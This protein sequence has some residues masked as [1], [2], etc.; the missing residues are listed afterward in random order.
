MQDTQ[1]DALI[2]EELIQ[3]ENIRTS[4]E[5]TPIVLAF[6]ETSLIIV[7]LI[8]IGTLVPHSIHGDG[9]IR[10]QSL[11]ELVQQHKWSDMPYSFVGPL[12]SLPFWLLGRQFRNIEAWCEQYNLFIFSTGLLITYLIVQKRVN[13]SLLR[14]FFLLLIAAS[15]FAN[16][17]PTYYGEVFTAILM[18][19]GIIA[20]ATNRT[21]LGRFSGWV[22]IILGVVNIPASLV[23]LGL[24]ILK[25]MF[26]N[27]R[28]RYLL[29]ILVA[30]GLVMTEAWLRRGGPFVSG[31][32]TAQGDPTVMP[33]TGKPG[34][35]YPFW[36]GLLS[37]LF[38][39]GKGLLFFASGLVL[40]VRKTLLALK[41]EGDI[42]LYNVYLLWL[43][44][45]VGLVLVY[46]RWWSWYG[47]WFWGPRFFLFASI[48]ASFALAVRLHK[49]NVSLPVNLLTLGVLCLSAWVGTD[50]AIFSQTQL[51]TVCQSNNYQYEMLC[52]YTPDFSA[53]W[54][55]FIVP[56]HFTQPQ[57][58]YMTYCGIVF[59][60]LAFPLFAKIVRQVTE[61][62]TKVS[63]EHL[64]I[65]LWK[66]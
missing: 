10:L 49:R 30:A 16:H 13:H 62:A 6:I 38:S 15:M 39:F 19:V 66:I 1:E 33:F 65:R 63:K 43:F 23:G 26:S 29:A 45:L 53:L 42:D 35:S 61:L 22:A 59:V 64:N 24:V 25:K 11:S 57:L 7:G 60:Y 46:S 18:G 8:A 32:E 44:F 37:I 31:Y 17:I 27:K 5:W 55:P 20:A 56:Q 36:F 50:G 2:P 58:L 28:L 52:H 12:F 14:K 47:G 3:K 9:S 54:H 51:S 4:H 48:P 34:F 21:K 41:K 40:P